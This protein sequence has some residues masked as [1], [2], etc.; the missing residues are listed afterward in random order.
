MAIETLG[1]ALRQINRLF[2]EGV[3][4]GL[5]DAQLLE[6]FLAHGDAGAFEALV[7]RHGPMV[8]SVC[9]GIL[10]DPND[11][12][13]AFQATFLVLVKKAG[14]IRGRRR[15]WGAGCTGS[16]TASR[17][18]PTSPRPG[19]APAKGEAGQMAAATTIDRPGRPGRAPAGAARGDRPAAREV[20]P[21]RRALR[22]G[23]HAPGRRP[24]SHCTG[25]SGRSDA[26]SPRRA[27]GSSAG[28]PAAGWRPTARRSAAVFLREAQAAVP[29]AWRE[30]T[31]RAAVA[32]VNRT[33]DRRGRLGGSSVTDPGGAQDHVG[34]EADTRHRPPCW[35]PALIGWGASAA[36]ISRGRSPARASAPASIA[37][38]RPSRR[39]AA[40]S[41]APPTPAGTFPVRGRVLDPDGKPVAGAGVY[42]RH[43]AEV[44][45]SEIDPMAARQKGRVASTDAD[46]RF[47][48]ELD[49]GA[50]DGSYY[51]GVTG[52][53]KAQIAV[54]AP[55]FAPAWVEAGDAGQAGRDGAAAGPGRRARPRACPGSAR[56][57][58]RRGDRA[59]PSDLGGQRRGRPRRHA[60]LGRGG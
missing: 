18:R 17:S 13:D 44:R 37:R 10:R 6:R 52:W 20:P 11:A 12:E 14:T 49:K 26:G 3:V 32:V 38:P 41:R 59:D 48:F 43:Y 30:A 15:R 58:R 4:A 40:E 34:A 57:A 5:S 50:S 36:L 28:W 16:R 60:G 31:V 9:R 25:A 47:H 7:A 1:A 55:G 33:I 53:H 29:P 27:I 45:W 22:P 54:A 2:A 19:G 42:V 21:G 35:E 23:G 56:P 8:L 51:S 46:G 39:P 24:P